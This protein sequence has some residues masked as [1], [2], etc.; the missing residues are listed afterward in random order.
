MRPVIV[1]LIL[2]ILSFTSFAYGANSPKASAKKELS[3]GFIYISP[4]AT[5]GFSYSHDIARVALDKKPNIRTF[6]VDNISEGADAEDVM[7]EMARKKTDIIIATS[8]GFM[9]ATEI[10][11]KQYPEQVFLHCSGN[12]IGPNLSS[13]FGRIYQARYLTGMTAGLMTSSDTI[14]YVAAYPIPEVV[15][16]I[17]AFTLGVQAVNPKAKVHVIWTRTWYDPVIESNATLKVIQSGAD[18]ITQHQDS[19]AVQQAAVEKGVYGIGYHSDMSH[20]SKDK[21]LVS[22]VWNWLP[23]YE[24]VVEKVQAGTWESGSFFYDMK[25]GIVD[26]SE[27]GKAVPESARAQVLKRR[28]ELIDG[29]YVVFSGPVVTTEG[30]LKVPE[31]QVLPDENLFSMDWFVKGVVQLD[32]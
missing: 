19:F 16:G 22:A 31:G 4:V 20:L 9:D 28:Q 5:E 24:E 7:A 18:V 14:G 12:K 29:S 23:F 11:A 32:N 25:A 21:H 17:N 6:Y 10:I 3:I 26:I 8:Y 27:F 15:R 1:T 13:F 2:C 30:E